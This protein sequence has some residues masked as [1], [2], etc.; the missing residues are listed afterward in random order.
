MG[1]LPYPSPLNAQVSKRMSRN[2]RR[3][4]RPERAL[5]SA[6]HARGAR[7]RVDHKLRL[8]S[9]T[10]RPDVV[11]TRWRIAVFLDGCFWHSCPTHGNLPQRNRDY[12]EPKLRRNVDRDRRIDAALGGA[13]WRVIR[14]WEHEDKDAVA[15]RVLSSV[16]A[17]AAT[18]ANIADS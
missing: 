15:G 11:F 4:T 1:A 18:H 2:P 14:A 8:G 7:F 6:L 17:R 9:L 16:A 5:R 13:G 3:D 10:V 12:W